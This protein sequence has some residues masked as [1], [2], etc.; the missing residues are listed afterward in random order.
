MGTH[1]DNRDSQSFSI[2]IYGMKN[3]DVKIYTS[4]RDG[5]RT[6][7]LNRPEKRNAFDQSMFPMLATIL[8]EASN[9]EDVKACVITGAGDSFSSGNDLGNFL[10]ALSSGQFE[11]K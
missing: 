3:T 9:D 5:V 10:T 2:I 1:E 4:D 11:S 7:T 6:I 8:E